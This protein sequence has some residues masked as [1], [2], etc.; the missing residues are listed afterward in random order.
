MF[1]ACH[2]ESQKSCDKK[3]HRNNPQHVQSESGSRED[4]YQKQDKQKHTHVMILSNSLL[5]R[6]ATDARS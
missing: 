1:A 4:Q 2:D 5:G 6:L 3:H